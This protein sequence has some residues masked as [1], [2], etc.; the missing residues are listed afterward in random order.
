MDKEEAGSGIFKNKILR[1][2]F[3]AGAGFLVD[4]VVFFL[5]D[6]YV[7]TRQS[8]NLLGINLSSHALA[9]GIS[10]FTGVLVN[11]LMSRYLVFTKSRL[12][13]GQQLMRFG[14]VAFAGYFANLGM[15]ELMIKYLH[16]APY[17]ARITASLTLFFASY[18]VHKAFSFSLSLRHHHQSK[19]HASAN[20]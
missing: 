17:V 14:L 4:V 2:I 7:F 12:P 20:H 3:S 5:L 9:L 1:F 18:F 13:F 8:N 11:F 10:F 15:L 16:L 6:R 19:H